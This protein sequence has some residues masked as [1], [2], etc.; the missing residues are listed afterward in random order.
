MRERERPGDRDVVD[1]LSGEIA[2]LSISQLIDALAEC[3]TIGQASGGQSI[4]EEMSAFA[5]NA[6]RL[7][8]SGCSPMGTAAS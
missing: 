5:H 3:R 6:I 2:Q 4:G 8:L 1:W 7:T